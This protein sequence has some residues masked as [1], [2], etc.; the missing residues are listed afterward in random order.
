MFPKPNTKRDRA[1]K[2]RNRS[3]NLQKWFS[4]IYKLDGKKCMACG[5][6]NMMSPAHHIL[7]RSKF[8]EFIYALWNGIQLCMFC[9]PKAEDGTKEQTARQWMIGILE[10]LPE[11]HRCKR[12]LIELK[13]KEI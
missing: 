10:E 13:K 8:I 6:T 12:A 11:G 1:K 5:R 7:S 3:H 9:H 4:S 2:K